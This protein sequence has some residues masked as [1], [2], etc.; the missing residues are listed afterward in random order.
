[1]ALKYWTNQQVN[2][3]SAIAAGVAITAA[4]KGANCQISTA[5]AVPSNGAYILI[6][7]TGMTQLNQR[8]YKVS[9]AGA[10]VFNIGVDS[11]GFSTFAAGT[12]RVITFGLA[13]NSLRD[14][15]SSG[16]DPVF[17]D[18]TTIHDPED[19][20]AIVSSSP[21]SFSATAD[22]EPTD[23]TLIACNTAYI[24]RTT[25]A[26]QF[27]DPDGSEYLFNAYLNAP[28]SPTVSGKKKVT[29]IAWSLRAS[30]T[31]Y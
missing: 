5:G 22:W 9:G 12:F 30:G 11:T 7:C 2:M 28:L 16:G 27:K 13:F 21:L 26:V 25:R 6:E 10:G 4:T 17:E 29:P 18:T 14:I 24:T 20:Q 23:A 1:M 8:V 15:S 3:Q 19:T 31:A